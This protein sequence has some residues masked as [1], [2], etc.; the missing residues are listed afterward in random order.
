MSPEVKTFLDHLRD[1][2]FFLRRLT[3]SLKSAE[4]NDQRRGEIADKMAQIETELME[5]YPK[6]VELFKPYLKLGNI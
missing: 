4:N 3:V 2:T 6:L 1:K 5:Q